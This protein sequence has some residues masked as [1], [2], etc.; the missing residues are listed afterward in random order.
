MYQ[1]ECEYNAQQ[2][3]KRQMPRDGKGRKVRQENSSKMH[4]R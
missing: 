1:L 3:M 4:I 2:Q